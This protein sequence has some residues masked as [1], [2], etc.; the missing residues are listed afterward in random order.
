[1]PGERGFIVFGRRTWGMIRRCANR[2]AQRGSVT[3]ARTPL[4]SS[5][6]ALIITRTSQ[7]VG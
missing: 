6:R 5:G 4:Q 7:C 2:S 1:M 3:S